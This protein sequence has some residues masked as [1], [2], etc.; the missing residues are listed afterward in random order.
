MGLVKKNWIYCIIIEGKIR[1]VGMTNDVNKRQN[2]H[3]LNLKKKKDN[4][5]YRN[6]NYY[7]ID[8]ELTLTPIKSFD[9]RS[10]AMRYEAYL[11]LK[12]YFSEKQLWNKPPRSIKYF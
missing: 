2:Q 5:L 3:R 7:N 12:D 10:D 11:I 8:V 4:L 9:N 6:I 1:Y